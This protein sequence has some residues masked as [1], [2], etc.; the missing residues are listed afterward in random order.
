MPLLPP[1]LYRCFH[2]GVFGMNWGLPYLTFVL[3]HV[4]PFQLLLLLY[5]NLALT[6]QNPFSLS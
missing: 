6:T 4:L 1:L 2:Q 3:C 5:I